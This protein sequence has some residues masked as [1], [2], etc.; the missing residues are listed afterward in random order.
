MLSVMLY[1]TLESLF[2]IISTPSHFDFYIT[3]LFGFSSMCHLTFFRCAV[4]FFLFDKLYFDVDVFKM[5]ELFSI[6]F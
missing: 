2:C 6:S 1:I 5:Y 4:G 3:A